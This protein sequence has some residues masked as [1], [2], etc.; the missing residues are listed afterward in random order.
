MICLHCRKLKGEI[1]MLKKE[2]KMFK[3]ELAK[4][5]GGISWRR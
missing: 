4:M 1:A 3:A 5:R 2:I